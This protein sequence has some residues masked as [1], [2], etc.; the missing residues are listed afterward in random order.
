MT[1]AYIHET[2]N[3]THRMNAKYSKV[4]TLHNEKG[5]KG[6]KAIDKTNWQ[7]TLYLNPIWGIVSWKGKTMTIQ[8]HDAALYL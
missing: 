1:L 8:C 6:Q 7:K 4:T 3:I 2:S 5:R